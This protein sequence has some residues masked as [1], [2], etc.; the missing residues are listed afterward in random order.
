MTDLHPVRFGLSLDPAADRLRETLALAAA[1]E[2]AGLDLLAVQDHPYHPAHLDAMTLLGVLGTAT[3]TIGLVTDVADLRLRPPALLAKAAASLAVV[4]GGR[5]DLGVGGGGIPDAIT[6]MGAPPRTPGEVI[7]YT[8]ESLHVLRDALRG[9]PVLL[10]GEQLSVP[11]YR[12]GPVPVRPPELWLGAQRPR[13]LGVA[14]RAADAWISP[15]NIYVRPEEVPALQRIVDDA[16]TAAGRRPEDVRRVYNVI[17]T[18]G[19]RGAGLTGSAGEWADTLTDW[20]VRLGFDT[21]VFWPAA[22]P[23]A[24]LDV[25]ANEVV[26]AV[27]ARV[28]EGVRR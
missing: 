10:D 6:S 2:H 14:G 13:M 4:T 25:F 16:A 23:F 8:E 7:T 27:R 5:V 15:L 28:S 11:G 3:T 26:P 17:G 21:F 19:G 18:I 24:Q 22:D 9:G 1:A 20:T 12:A